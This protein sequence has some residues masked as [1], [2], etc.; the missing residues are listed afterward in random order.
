[1]CLTSETK[2]GV[3]ASTGGFENFQTLTTNPQ[4]KF[5]PNIVGQLLVGILD[6]AI[7]EME[8]FG[9]SFMPDVLIWG[10]DTPNPLEDPLEDK[11]GGA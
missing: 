7:K 4:Y 9:K 2:A 8:E 1:M 11:D 3:R 5:N 6:E 10:S